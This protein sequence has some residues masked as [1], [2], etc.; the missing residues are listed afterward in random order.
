MSRHVPTP[1][2]QPGQQIPPRQGVRAAARGAA[3][4]AVR[5]AAAVADRIH[6][7][8]PG[9][10]FVIYHQ[11]NGPKPGVVNLP[12]ELFEQQM[13]ELAASG[14]VMSIDDAVRGLEPESD[15]PLQ[16]PATASQCPV[17]LT[18]DDGTADFV[19][20]ALP[21][22]VRLGLPAVLYVATQ[23]V[24]EQR[25]FWDDGTVLSWQALADAVA[26]GLVTIGSHTHGH[27]HADTTPVDVFEHDLDRSIDLIGSNLGV[28]ASHFAYPKA[29]NPG[30]E[31]DAA[32]RKRFVSAA[33]GGCRA[34]VPGRA[35]PH[36]LMR[37]PLQVG[38]GMK[39]FRRKINGGMHVEEWIRSSIGSARS[40]MGATSPLGH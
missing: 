32:V 37:S 30:P 31:V 35:D 36:G 8:D 15:E 17:V 39:G 1:S 19:D 9:V 6:P 29:L 20:N 3:R 34:N 10:V 25:S 27:L 13:E 18:F 16:V 24:D 22:L 28:T 23:W 21:V 38:E 11:V 26:T 5:T 12:L 33:V 40:R 2:A 7:P 14:R 4:S